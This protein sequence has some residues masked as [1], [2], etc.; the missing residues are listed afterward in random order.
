MA[1]TRAPGPGRT[2]Q[3]LPP[4]QLFRPEQRQVVGFWGLREEREEGAPGSLSSG[5]GAVVAVCGQQGALLERAPL[6]GREVPPRVPDPHGPPRI[7]SVPAGCSG[8]FRQRRPAR[9]WAAGE[10]RGPA[11]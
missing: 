2:Q 5:K 10:L 7:P 3:S 6:G 9:R 4:S 11:R 1:R 8:H